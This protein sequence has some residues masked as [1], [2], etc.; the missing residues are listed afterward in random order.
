MGIPVRAALAALSMF[1]VCSLSAAPASGWQAVVVET[2]P[3]S[4]DILLDDG[5]RLPL[6][7]P[8][9]FTGGFGVELRVGGRVAASA[10]KPES[11]KAE[12]AV[13]Q[14]SAPADWKFQPGR[15]NFYSRNNL[16]IPAD[17]LIAGQTIDLEMPEL[18]KSASSGGSAPI[19]V[20]ISL[21]ANYRRETPHPVIV[22]FGGGAGGSGEAMR[23]RGIVGDDNFI[24][25]G[26]DYDYDENVK[27]GTLKIGTCRDFDSRIALYILQALRNSTMIDADTVILSGYSSGAYSITDNLKKNPKAWQPFSGF[28][29]IAGGSRTG[30]PQ[31]RERPILFLMGKEDTLRHGWMNEAVEGLKKGRASSVTVRMEEGVGHEWSGVYDPIIRE[32]LAEHFPTVGAAER[33]RKLLDGLEDPKARA[34]VQRWIDNSGLR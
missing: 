26:A 18:G 3:G 15:R 1:S 2:G 33:R 32:W 19:M 16:V 17:A 28:C 29:A 22:H 9:A 25:V 30:S 20:K 31:I 4:A 27:A 13:L 5:R 12:R 24:I 21:P 7:N 10:G 8:E 14:E 11:F 6:A 23:Y 34:V